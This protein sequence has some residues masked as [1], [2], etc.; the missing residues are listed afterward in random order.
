VHPPK[1]F[2]HSSFDSLFPIARVQPVPRP[3]HYKGLLS[4]VYAETG[5]RFALMRLPAGSRRARPKAGPF[6][7]IA[8]GLDARVARLRCP[9]LRPSKK[10]VR[11]MSARFKARRESMTCIGA[12]AGSPQSGKRRTLDGLPATGWRITSAKLALKPI[13]GRGPANRR[14]FLDSR[15]RGNDIKS[16][17]TSLRSKAGHYRGSAVVFHLKLPAPPI[18][19][20][21]CSPARLGIKCGWQRLGPSA[22]LDAL[23]AG[24]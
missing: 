10:M 4:Q 5:M 16:F 3:D 15:F 11:R 23:D 14:R 22:S 13:A 21:D 9:I 12:P 1:G 7:C 19:I 2:C 24:I 20:M 18:V 8:A 17:P 6:C